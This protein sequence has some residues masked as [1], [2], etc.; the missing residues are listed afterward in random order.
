ML[1]RDALAANTVPTP[2]SGAGAS[3]F[4]VHTVG[5]L[6]HCATRF[7]RHVWTLR[8]WRSPRPKIYNNLLTLKHIWATNVLSKGVYDMRVRRHHSRLI[9]VP[10]ET[11]TWFWHKHVA[12]NMPPV[13]NCDKSN[14]FMSDNMCPLLDLSSILSFYSPIAID[15]FSAL[16]DALKE[17]DDQLY[18]EAIEDMHNG[19]FDS[20]N[21]AHALESNDMARFEMEKAAHDAFK[22]AVNHRRCIAVCRFCDLPYNLQSKL[23]FDGDERWVAI[24]PAAYVHINIH[25][26]QSNR[27][28]FG[29]VDV[30]PH[31]YI[32]GCVIYVGSR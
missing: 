13:P 12:T 20:L 4:F 18:Q 5:F 14:W 21:H 28:T 10:E 2:E 25:W 23:C 8:E 7:F 29:H 27:S 1:T 3:S 19:T 26:L 15:Y 6:W 32:E 31:P 30:F 16:E 24:V 11:I 22:T 17:R 9:D